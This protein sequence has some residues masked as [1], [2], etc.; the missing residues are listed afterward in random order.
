MLRKLE[1]RKPKTWKLLVY[2]TALVT[3]VAKLLLQKVSSRVL[4]W[5]PLLALVFALLLISIVIE[6][7]SCDALH[8]HILVING[9]FTFKRCINVSF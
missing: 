8:N 6:L 2:G 7:H 9:T 4:Y 1:A 3:M 5:L